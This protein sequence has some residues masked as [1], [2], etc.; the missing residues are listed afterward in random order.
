LTVIKGKVVN[1]MSLV[2]L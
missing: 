2:L 1:I